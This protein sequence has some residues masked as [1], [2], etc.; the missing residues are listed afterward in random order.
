L[1]TWQVHMRRAFIMMLVPLMH[2]YRI[3]HADDHFFGTCRRLL[4]IWAVWTEEVHN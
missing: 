1:V 4:A 2:R 3:L